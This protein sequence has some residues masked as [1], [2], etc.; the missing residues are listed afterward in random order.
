TASSGATPQPSSSPPSNARSAIGRSGGQDREEGSR[1][2]FPTAPP[3][4]SG[5][6]LDAGVP[7]MQP[8]RPEHRTGRADPLHP[9]SG[10][11]RDAVQRVGRPPD[12]HREFLLIM[13]GNPHPPPPWFERPFP[14]PLRIK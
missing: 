11:A 14:D 10:R 4:K 7:E 3:T 1:R 6:V 12:L 2:L 8:R 13:G 5:N 9:R